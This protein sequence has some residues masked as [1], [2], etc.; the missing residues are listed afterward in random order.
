MSRGHNQLGF[1]LMNNL[2]RTNV[3]DKKVWNF[4][5]HIAFSVLLAG[6]AYVAK[7]IYI[8][9]DI[10]I[11]YM[12]ESFFSNNGAASI[13]IISGADKGTTLLSIVVNEYTVFFVLLLLMYVPLRSIV[14]IRD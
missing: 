3:R 8:Y 9:G 5:R 1:G 2:G 6:L 11:K 14:G 10:L 12:D 13:A 4:K 7:I